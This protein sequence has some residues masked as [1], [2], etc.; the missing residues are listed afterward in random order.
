MIRHPLFRHPLDLRV[1]IKIQNREIPIKNPSYEAYHALFT[2]Q[3]L[4][5]NWKLIPENVERKQNYEMR[6]KKYTLETV[7]RDR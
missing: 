1:G 3:L 6:N 5:V 2:V 4:Y 7:N